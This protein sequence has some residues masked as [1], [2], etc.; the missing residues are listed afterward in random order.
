MP[1][2]P[3]LERAGIATDLWRRLDALRG[4]R[5]EE[6]IRA[7]AEAIASAPSFDALDLQNST[8]TLMSSVQDA[9]ASGQCRDRRV[10]HRRWIVGLILGLARRG[11]DLDEGAYIIAYNVVCIAVERGMI[12]A[13][14]ARSL[15]WSFGNAQRRLGWQE[16]RGGRIQSA[17]ARGLS[18]AEVHLAGEVEPHVSRWMRDNLVRGWRAGEFWGRMAP[19]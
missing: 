15:A 17:L 7:M 14:V 8:A 19:R 10:L 16:D 1:S 12:L 18:D 5:G 9:L 2:L 3:D 11:Y 6:A 13:V 4:E